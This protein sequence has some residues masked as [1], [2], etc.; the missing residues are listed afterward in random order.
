MRS[1][2]IIQARDHVQHSMGGEIG[3]PF[4]LHANRD[5]V[6]GSMPD[7]LLLASYSAVSGS[8]SRCHRERS[9]PAHGVK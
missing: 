4:P 5:E 1:S 7:A 9:D 2:C 6:A 3:Q 8:I